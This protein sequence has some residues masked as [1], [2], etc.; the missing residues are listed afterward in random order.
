MKQEV[1][2]IETWLISGAGQVEIWIQSAG[3]QQ[4][5]C[6]QMPGNRHLA[7]VYQ[8]GHMQVLLKQT[9]NL[10]GRLKEALPHGL[11]NNGRW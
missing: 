2:K 9:R 6:F 8:I 7:L 3:S 5:L 1:Q 10:Q 11:P 4:E